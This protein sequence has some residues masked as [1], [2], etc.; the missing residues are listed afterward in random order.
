MEG[1]AWSLVQYAAAGGSA[2]LGAFVHDKVVAPPAELDGLDMMGLLARWHELRDVLRGWEPDV[3]A[4]VPEAALLA[5]LTYPA[6]ILCAGA[7]Y[8]DHLSEMGIDRPASPPEPFFFFKPPTTT[9]IGPGATIRLPRGDRRIDWEGELGVVIA[10]RCRDLTPGQVADHVAG[11]V[12]ANDISARARL[13]RTDAVAAPFGFD[14]VGSK[15]Q[16]GFCPLGPGLVP[17]WLVGDPQDLGLRLTVNGA[18]KQDAHT[19]GMITPVV[20]LVAAVSAFV[21]LE[22]GDVVLTGT[23]AGV[24]LPRGEFLTPGDEV[25]VEIERVGR[26]VNQVA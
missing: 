17:E 14:W 25:V 2:R 11:Y 26:L 8:Y 4:V 16:D 1:P 15:A 19:S 5:P 12:A 18:V 20:E 6:K 3:D 13:A 10:D 21:T 23:P 7:N 9:V 24:G 22:P